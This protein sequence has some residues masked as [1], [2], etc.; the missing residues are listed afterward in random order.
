MSII[1]LTY[2]ALFL[3]SDI[4]KLNFIINFSLA[5]IYLGIGIINFR[6]LLNKIY[7]V[8]KLMIENQNDN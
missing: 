2:S 4:E 3:A 5:L 1:Y 8:K 6:N 7:N